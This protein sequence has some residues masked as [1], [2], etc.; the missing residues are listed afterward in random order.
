MPAAREVVIKKRRAEA[1]LPDWAREGV[2][3]VTYLS[4]NGFL[5][6]VMERFRIER[7]G[8]YVGIDAVLLLLFYF[9]SGIKDGLRKFDGRNA[10]FREQLA[11]LGGRDSLPTQSSMS[12][13]LGDATPEAVRKVGRWILREGAEVVSV[14]RHPSMLTVDALMRCWHVFD[15]DPTKKPLRQRA[16]PE[17]DDLPPARRRAE[18]F[19]AP[20]HSGR[21]RGEVQIS[22]SVLQHA[23]SSI[24]LDS[25]LAPGNGEQRAQLGSALEAVVDVC[26]E[27]DH[28]L[29]RALVRLDGEFGNVPS[30]TALREAGVSGITRFNRLGLLN[31][32]EILQSM[33][34]HA[35]HVVPDSRS[36]PRRSA[37]DLGVVT[38]RPSH[39]TVDDD[40]EPYE[41]IDVR[42]VVSRYARKDKAEHGR[43]IDG[44]QYELFAALDLDAE[45]WPAPDVVASYFG[46]GGQENR[47]AQED[48]EL[49]L[50]HIFSYTLAGQELACI[51]GLLVWNIR[52]VQGFLLNP[53]P[54]KRSP[55]STRVAK[56][57]PR[58]V[59]ERFVEALEKDDD[60]E[61]SA[62]PVPEDP[63]VALVDLLSDLDWSHLLRRHPDWQFEQDHGALR[64]PNGQPAILSSANKNAG[65][66]SHRLHFRAPA[67]ACRVCPL[68]ASCLASARADAVKQVGL[69]VPKAAA[70]L[71]VDKLVEV[72]LARRVERSVELHA[73]PLSSGRPRHPRVGEPLVVRPPQ[74]DER[75][76]D[77]QISDGQFLP[78]VARGAFRSACGDI[79]VQ[80]TV[81]K[82]RKEAPHP[83]LVTTPARRQHRR[84]T[85]TE[86]N[87]RYALPNDA[88]VSLIVEGGK[89]L[90]ALLHHG[91]TPARTAA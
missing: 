53:L 45:G 24:W 37:M 47:F 86:R 83:Y 17:G 63:H 89:R 87:A 74:R 39:K 3:V 33:A 16:L 40:G 60:H 8:G 22:R 7:S 85:W 58:P 68:R 46:R 48:R 41:T 12:R 79:V 90:A 32:P 28:P 25:R 34:T 84:L 19:A 6:R 62:D 51:I 20:G 11:A 13:V 29:N 82:S 23:G 81:V 38:M 71:I 49:G 80:V 1:R 36:G 15:Y 55:T 88:T 54:D 64:C 50:D 78:A 91:E 56:V 77:W 5:Q 76:G 66:K 52:V 67:G 73:K 70:D 21:K 42:V 57:D 75:P 14:L 4:E 65:P 10:G 26:N 59:P 27:L 44:W 61:P 30:L 72:Q 69:A 35:W 43:V 2:V 31:Q 18:G 9:S